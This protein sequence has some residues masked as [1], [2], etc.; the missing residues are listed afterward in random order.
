MV[1]FLPTTAVTYNEDAMVEYKDALWKWVREL[2]DILVQIADSFNFGD[3]VDNVII[4]KMDYIQD[5]ILN[6]RND[7]SSFQKLYEDCFTN[8]SNY[9]IDETKAEFTGYSLFYGSAYNILR[10]CKTVN[11]MLHVLHCAIVNNENYYKIMPIRSKK[12]NLSQE[13][14]ILYGNENPLAEQVFQ[15]W[16]FDLDC[17]VTDIVG[18]E[19]QVLIMVRDRGH[20]LSIEITKDEKNDIWI[21]YFIPKICNIDMVNRLNGIRAVKPNEKGAIGLIRTTQEKLSYDLFHFIAS[22]PTDNDMI[23][24]NSNPYFSDTIDGS[25]EMEEQHER[26]IV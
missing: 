8:M 11:E 7:Y 4:E 2:K 13:S 21:H 1:E 5:K 6:T 19:N 14:I 24:S 20:A 17:G 12:E 10:E 15:T 18:L 22:V 25:N 26:K 3:G 23:L 9:I 16:P